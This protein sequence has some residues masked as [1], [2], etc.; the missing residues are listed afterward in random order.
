MAILISY[1]NEDSPM[2]S[3]QLHTALAQRMGARNFIF[4]VNNLIDPGDIVADAIKQGV[5]HCDLLM[6]FIGQNW[7]STTWSQNPT[8]PDTLAITTAQATGKRVIPV[9]LM[10]GFQLDRNAL[11]PSVAS[12]LDRAPFVCKS[13]DDVVKLTQ[14]LQKFINPNNAVVAS[15][16][17]PSSSTS[18][19]PVG[20]DA[21]V[22]AKPMFGVQSAAKVDEF[23]IEQ[24]AVIA[25]VVA[26]SGYQ[27][28]FYMPFEGAG[29]RTRVPNGADVVVLA[30]DEIS[31][32]L[33]VVYISTTGQPIAGWIPIATTRNVSYLGMPVEVLDLPISQYEYNSF[34][35]IRQ[36]RKHI[37]KSRQKVARK[38]LIITLL[39]FGALGF[40]GG[41][42]D[43]SPY[44][45]TGENIFLGVMIGIVVGLSLFWIP[46]LYSPRYKAFSQQIVRMKSIQ[47]SKKGTGT[48]SLETLAKVGMAAAGVAGMLGAGALAMK[49]RAGEKERQ[50]QQNLANKGA[51]GRIDIHKK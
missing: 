21:P 11:A 43:S 20:F 16:G 2:L 12:L 5:Q 50:H 29:I 48:L 38:Y 35:E 3:N 45:E 27:D 39:I 25:Q 22:E 10:D 33:N 8:D 24:N 34:D 32:W 15:G 17:A 42:V 26:P 40:L 46:L 23:N 18:N 51:Y 28:L 7:T 36:N 41:L 30:R 4:G 9:Y 19:K 49:G 44:S 6:V 13:E 31:P 37:D 14:T 1:R 47:Q